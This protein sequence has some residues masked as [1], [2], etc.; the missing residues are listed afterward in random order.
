MH[1][2]QKK[3]YDLKKLLKNIL[4]KFFQILIKLI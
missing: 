3:K 4:E 1:L 2:I